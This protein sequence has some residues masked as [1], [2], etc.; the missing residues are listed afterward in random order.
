MGSLQRDLRSGH[1]AGMYLEQV[2]RAYCQTDQFSVFRYQP[3]N[4]HGRWTVDGIQPR[5]LH[6]G[7][8]RTLCRCHLAFF[9]FITV[10]EL[11]SPVFGRSRVLVLLSRMRRFIIFVTGY[12]FLYGYRIQK[13]LV[14]F[15]GIRNLERSKIYWH[16][17]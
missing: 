1:D 12:C 3:S 15:P 2:V 8:N 11:L 5:R 6:R 4:D 10:F 7:Y 14:I 13:I 16:S 17:F 9:L